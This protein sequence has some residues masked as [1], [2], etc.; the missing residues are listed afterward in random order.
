M[1]KY[2]FAYAEDYIQMDKTRKIYIPTALEKEFEGRKFVV[3]PM[4]DGDIVLHPVKASKDPLKDFQKAL[5]P[6][7]GDPKQIKKEILKTAMEGV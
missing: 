5:G 2:E 7:K 3:L 4:P 6:V 1:T